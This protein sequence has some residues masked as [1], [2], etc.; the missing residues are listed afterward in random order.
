[1]KYLTANSSERRSHQQK[2]SFNNNVDNGPSQHT[3]KKSSSTEALNNAQPNANKKAIACPEC[4]KLFGRVSHMRRHQLVHSGNKPFQCDVCGDSFTRVENR[5]RHMIVHTKQ[6]PYNCECGKGFTQLNRLKVHRLKHSGERPFTCAVCSKRF[7]RVDHLRVHMRTHQANVDAESERPV[8]TVEQSQRQPVKTEQTTERLQCSPN[9][10]PNLPSIVVAQKRPSIS[11]ECAQQPLATNDSTS[12]TDKST[13]KL[14][15]C[16]ECP[17]RFARRDHF[18]RHIDV[19]SGA[20][21]FQCELCPKT[22]SRKDNKYSHMVG[23]LLKNYGIMVETGG[24]GAGAVQRGQLQRTVDERVCDVLGHAYMEPVTQLQ[25][26]GEADDIDESEQQPSG[27]LENDEDDE[28]DGEMNDDNIGYGDDGD[29]DADQHR[30]ATEPVQSPLGKLKL[31]NLNELAIEPLLLPSQQQEQA[32]DVHGV[33]MKYQC[34]GDV[35]IET[36]PIQDSNIHKS[37]LQPIRQFQCGTCDK[38]FQNKS[39]LVRH[40]ALHSSNRPFRCDQCD[41]AFNRKEH[42]QRHVIVHTGIKPFRCSYCD[43]S[44]VEQNQQRRHVLE[45]HAAEAAAA[46]AGSVR[47]GDRSTNASTFTGV[48]DSAILHNDSDGACMM[49]SGKYSAY[50]H[51][52]VDQKRLL[53]FAQAKHSH[54]QSTAS[55]TAIAVIA[56]TPLSSACVV[57]TPVIRATKRTSATIASSVSRVPNTNAVTWPFIRMRSVSSANSASVVSFE[58]IIC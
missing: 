52:F 17:K 20:R 8:A 36:D 31:R 51:V 24:N 55:I 3:G 14:F 10:E 48:D 47:K 54:R 22:F 2:S 11:D 33:T 28:A 19:H 7:L 37:A 57:T 27:P 35:A 41:K 25:E 49:D 43:R 53:I 30:S 13:K 12:A 16:N 44:F 6:R 26:Y 15:Q 46:A 32:N 50:I 56:V 42:L 29:I 39:H 40:A 23:C 5:D 4:G 9:V 21:P 34:L 1:M 18:Q 58:P 45:E 38:H